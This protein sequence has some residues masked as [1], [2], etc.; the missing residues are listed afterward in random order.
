MGQVSQDKKCTNKDAIFCAKALV[1]S[2]IKAQKD[3]QMYPATNPVVIESLEK[4]LVALKQGFTTEDN[5]ELLVDKEC[6]FV[7]GIS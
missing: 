3:L 4:T 6:L 1:S 7:N 2:L 5:V